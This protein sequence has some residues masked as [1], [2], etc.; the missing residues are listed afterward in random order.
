[1]SIKLQVSEAAL[2]EF[3]V[4]L[5]RKQDEIEHLCGEAVMQATE[6]LFKKVRSRTPYKTGALQQSGQ[7]NYKRTSDRTGYVGIISFGNNNFNM[8]TGETTNEYAEIVH[9]SPGYGYKWFENIF[10]SSADVYKN[11]LNYYIKKAF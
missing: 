4:S 1:M 2:Y 9:E 6:T 8:K 7:T 11:F 10:N 3:E 5:M